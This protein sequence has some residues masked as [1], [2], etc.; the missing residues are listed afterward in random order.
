MQTAPF[1]IVTNPSPILVS[2]VDSIVAYLLYEYCLPPLEFLNFQVKKSSRAPSRVFASEFFGHKFQLHSASSLIFCRQIDM[3]K[4]H[5]IS[6]NQ[7]HWVPRSKVIFTWQS[8]VEI[9]KMAISKILDFST[10]SK[11][12]IKLPQNIRYD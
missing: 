10:G 12:T 8:T 4:I 6:K 5:H 1:H 11:F 3:V 7:S 9:F 2:N